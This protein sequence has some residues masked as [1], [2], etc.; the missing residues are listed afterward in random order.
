MEEYKKLEDSLYNSLDKV[1]KDFNPINKYA[2]CR[3]IEETLDVLKRDKEKTAFNTVLILH[4]KHILNELKIV[5]KEKTLE[6]LDIAFNKYK[7]IIEL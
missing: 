5:N 7:D 1:K 4:V 3:Q 6:Q 2:M